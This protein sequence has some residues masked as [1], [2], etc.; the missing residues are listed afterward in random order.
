MTPPA[1]LALQHARWLASSAEV[2]W[3]TSIFEQP[4]LPPVSGLVDL[5]FDDAGLPLLF[6]P[7][8]SDSAI[9]SAATLA[10]SLAVP[11][12]ALGGLV[13]ESVAAVTLNG[14]LRPVLG[15]DGDPRTRL[16]PLGEE[17]LVFRLDVARVRYRPRPSLPWPELDLAAPV[18]REA[19]PGRA[20]HSLVVLL[21]H[22]NDAHEVQLRDLWAQLS[23]RAGEVPETVVAASVRPDSLELAGLGSAGVST[24]RLVFR[25]PVSRP[26]ELAAELLSRLRRAWWAPCP[27]TAP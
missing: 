27:R 9:A 17:Q 5:Q 15:P 22:L 19:G 24:A 18:W 23:G 6:L 4:A 10:A 2:G 11:E 7:P 21:D 12:P 1:V 3:L 16:S 26:G 8:A 14:R 25:R 13:P 20:P